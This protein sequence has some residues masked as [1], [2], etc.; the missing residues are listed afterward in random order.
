MPGQ[1]V[2]ALVS[3]SWDVCMLMAVT[4]SDP[5]PLQSEFI[6]SVSPKICR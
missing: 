6:Y 4:G 2:Q 1:F 5:E 3:P